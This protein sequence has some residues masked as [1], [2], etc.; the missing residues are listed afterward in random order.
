MARAFRL[1]PPR[2]E[3]GS[4]AG[5]PRAIVARITDMK[6]LPLLIVS[7][8]VSA[9]A[10]TPHQ[11]ATSAVSAAPAVVSPGG[12][13]PAAG[14]NG[15]APAQASAPSAQP[16]AASAP[17]PSGSGAAASTKPDAKLLREGYQAANY[18]GQTVY[19]RDESP[20]GSRFARRVCL[21]PEQI[22]AREENA[23][24]VLGTVHSDSSCSM[25][26]CQ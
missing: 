6:T 2:G 1:V 15:S 9:C 16:N 14:A 7:A 25:L 3:N 23:K 26:S 18:H 8:V 10:S 21:T 22:R 12:A 5:H 13:Q 4:H 24:D 20:T 11:P 17:L 19:C